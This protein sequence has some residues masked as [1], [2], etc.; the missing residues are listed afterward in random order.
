MKITDLFSRI[1]K[2]SAG[3]DGGKAARLVQPVQP[4]AQVGR[5]S[6]VPGQLLQGE[7]MGQDVNGLVLLKLAGEIISARTPINLEVGQQFW[8]EVKEAGDS[9]LLNLASQKGAIQD[10]LKDIMAT[11]PLLV[12]AHSAAN[13][14]S[15]SSPTPPQPE[16][17]PTAPPPAQ[18][19]S[20]G[21]AP[22]GQ[23]L[24]NDVVPQGSSS[25]ASV[26]PLASS[27]VVEADGSLPPEAA[28][29]VRAL[30]AYVKQRG[31][32]AA[33]LPEK[34]GQQAPLLIKTIVSLI[35]EG[36]IPVSLQKVEAFQG[37]IQASESS[38][39]PLALEGQPQVAATAESSLPSSSVSFAP[40]T[41]KVLNALMAVSGIKV[42][43]VGDE[44]PLQPALNPEQNLT[45]ILTLI[46]RADKIPG[47]LQKLSPLQLL[48]G[49]APQAGPGVISGEISAA[50]AENNGT[51]EEVAAA[52]S[53]ALLPLQFAAAQQGADSLPA[54]LRLLASL[55]GMGPQKAEMDGLQE[56]KEMFGGRLSEMEMP[57]AARK[58]ASFF[59][60]HTRVN[61]EVAPQGRSDFYI[62]PSV[63]TSQAG[64]GEW[65]WSRD[66]PAGNSKGSGQESLVFFL[67]M[68]NLG[69]LTIQVI[70]NEKKMRG[71]ILMADKKGSELVAALLPGL[72]ERL[73][74]FGYD[75]VAFPCSCQPLNVMQ[76]LKENLHNRVGSESVSLLDVQV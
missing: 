38:G 29:L 66:A 2:G 3:V 17:V 71:Q 60:A 59:E 27:V 23:S 8:F 34:G 72:R 7:V 54:Q 19:P 5:L 47:H 46:A 1:Q 39:A 13:S 42:P 68:S 75:V 70:L 55:M 6:L 28:R 45:E 56:L 32:S 52:A 11:R 21:P 65:L 40:E 48:M 25:P 61:T 33:A 36:Q 16:V 10:L 22:A 62:V 57:A 4:V 41:I 24:V 43:M 50:L 49:V 53:R 31:D 14:S 67:E 26:Q 30:V 51:L 73:A 37:V 18:G 20:S 69:A 9:P 64:W 74:G 58:L 12:N 76:E 44:S 15:S 35:R 63:F